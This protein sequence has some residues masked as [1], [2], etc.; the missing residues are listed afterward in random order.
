MAIIAQFDSDPRLSSAN[1][2]TTV[3]GISI[4]TAYY[5]LFTIFK[6]PDCSKTQNFFKNQ[7]LFVNGVRALVILV[8][9]PAFAKRRHLPKTFSPV[10]FI[11]MTQ[12]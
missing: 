3:P 7:S 1:H 6:T 2:Q 11:G 10:T 12:L 4:Y 9:V 5:L 8:R